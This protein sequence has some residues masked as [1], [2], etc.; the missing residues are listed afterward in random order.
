MFANVF[1]YIFRT[2]FHA[3]N[4]KN[5]NNKNNKASFRTFEHSSRSKILEFLTI[6]AIEKVWQ[7]LR[8][9]SSLTRLH[10]MERFWKRHQK[11]ISE[12]AD[13]SQEK[14]CRFFKSFAEFG[15]LLSLLWHGNRYILERCNVWFH[16]L[17][18][19]PYWQF[20]SQLTTSF[21]CLGTAA[22]MQIH[23]WYFHSWI[24]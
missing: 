24:I 13:F 4:N 16:Y 23:R 17:Q 21:I 9:H 8:F 7:D 2:W 1:C 15:E 19:T 20:F 11:A 5:K 14:R 12:N 3:N 18:F 6:I 10:L 22:C